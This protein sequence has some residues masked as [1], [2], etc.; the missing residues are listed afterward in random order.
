MDPFN[1]PAQSVH[2]S[3]QEPPSTPKGTIQSKRRDEVS[4]PERRSPLCLLANA[5]LGGHATC[6][7]VWR[8][9]AFT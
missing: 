9:R 4:L 2:A 6:L 8:R 1:T 3:S 7:A 5:L